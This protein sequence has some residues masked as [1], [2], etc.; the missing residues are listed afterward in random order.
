[1]KT[2]TLI[3]TLAAFAITAPLAIADN[4]NKRGE[5]RENRAELREKYENLSDAERAELRAKMETKRAE[6]REKYET[7]S[8]E[9]RAEFRKKMQRKRQQFR[10]NWLEGDRNRTRGEQPREN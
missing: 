1:M 4:A 7:L 8:D 2:H 9:E 5:W 3:I 10:N 6:L